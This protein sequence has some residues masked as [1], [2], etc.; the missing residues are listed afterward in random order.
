[1]L[2]LHVE[3]LFSMVICEIY[4]FDNKKRQKKELR[5]ENRSCHVAINF[6]AIGMRDEREVFNVVRVDVWRRLTK[7]KS[8]WQQSL[9]VY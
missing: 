7:K 1:M 8:V 6:I 2:R 4:D 9:F 3:S 5:W